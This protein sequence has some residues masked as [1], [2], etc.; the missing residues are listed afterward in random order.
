MNFV[1]ATVERGIV[2]FAGLEFP[3]ARSVP[4]GR[5]VL[6]IRPT[7][8]APTA[9]DGWPT[10]SIV[11]DVV[12]D[13]GDERYVIFEVEAARVDTDAVRAAMDAQT[14][15][16]VTLLADERARFTARLPA[17]APAAVGEPLEVAVDPS[18]LYFFDRDSGAK[19]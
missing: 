1:H 7:A 15:D 9:R 17:D 18:R 5:V 4:D 16:E 13:L 12:E 6:G 10:L 8:F 19:I 3:L 14:P 2:R 11:P